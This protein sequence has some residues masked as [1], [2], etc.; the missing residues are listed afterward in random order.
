MPRPLVLV[1]LLSLSSATAQG[2]ASGEIALIE[3]TG[4]QIR[5]GGIL[6]PGYLERA[7]CAFLAEHPDRYDVLFVFTAEPL[8][9]FTRT[10]QGWPLR[11][12]ATG[13][14]RDG[15]LDTT[16]RFCARRLRHV[17]KMGDIG[18]FSDDPDARY[19]GA[20]GFTLS[21]IELMAH[22]LG[23]QWLA[24]VAFQGPGGPRRCLHRGFT[25]PE[26]A[27]GTPA[28]EG[29]RDSDFNQHWSYY[30]SSGS[31][32]YGNSIE[33][34]G[35]GNFRISNSLLKYSELDQ[36]LMG[37]RDPSEVAP[38]FVV[39][40]GALTAEST[41]Y[42]LAA[43]QT[44]QLTGR[45][46]DFTIEDVIRA[47]GPRIPARETCHLKAAFVIVHPEGAPPAAAEV[48]R[49]DAHRRRFEE[50]YA[51]A[52]D[53]R[54]SMDTTLDGRGS[55]TDECPAVPGM[56]LDAGL[57]V[58]D[59]PGADAVPIDAA[60]DFERDAGHDAAVERSGSPDAD[61]V[62][63]LLV[64]EG[65]GCASSGRGTP[66][67]VSAGLVAALALALGVLRRRR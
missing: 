61:R 10:Q 41:A 38:M 45:R 12:A 25:P 51:W 58:P 16:S 55:G 13:I 7:A 35:G 44:E 23:H 66:D 29:Y 36:Y 4:G 1:T 5:R 9:A 47:E 33:D 65:C 6:L 53:R 48:A 20:P 57:G 56:A 39:D 42:P 34:L 54:G 17:V 62:R 11:P 37:L 32:M 27:P 8:T 43:G 2:A 59:V 26:E 24:A 63:T 31:V 52:T 28:C 18:S 21:A 19:T 46:V 60:G 67:P 64:D 50:Y 30:L 22:E 15:M 3:D 14:G 49:V 40:P